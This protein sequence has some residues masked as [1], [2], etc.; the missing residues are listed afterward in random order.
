MKELTFQLDDVI[1]QKLQVWAQSLGAL[2]VGGI[3]GHRW[4]RSTGSLLAN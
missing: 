4:Q 1:Y 2:W 3:K